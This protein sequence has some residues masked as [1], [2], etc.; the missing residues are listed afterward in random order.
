[1]QLKTLALAFNT[2]ILCNN[3]KSLEI[4]RFSLNHH[5]T[6]LVRNSECWH[7]SSWGIVL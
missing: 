3:F 6:P 1:M 7:N 4:D 5:N 2:I